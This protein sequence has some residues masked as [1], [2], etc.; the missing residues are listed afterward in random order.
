MNNYSK[1]SIILHKI[2]GDTMQKFLKQLDLSLKR[3][4]IVRE[5]N[6]CDIDFLG[7]KFNTKHTYLRKELFYKIII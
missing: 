7:F 2:K 1:Y 3:Y 6:K 5:I 4:E